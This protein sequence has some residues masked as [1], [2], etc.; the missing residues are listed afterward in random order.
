MGR[1]KQTYLKA[2]AEKL[3]AGHGEEFND[4]FENNKKKVQEFSTV[5]SKSIRNKIAGYISR[6]NAQT[7]AQEMRLEAKAVEEKAAQAAEISEESAKE[8]QIEELQR[9]EPVEEQLS[10]TKEKE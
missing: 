1:I 3:I 5:T 8:G 6:L 9:D 4:D 10:E 7:I 2:I